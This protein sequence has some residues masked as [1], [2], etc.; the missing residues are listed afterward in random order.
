[1]ISL[2][3]MKTRIALSGTWQC[4]AVEPGR[5]RLPALRGEVQSSGEVRG[6]IDLNML[7]DIVMKVD[8]D[9]EFLAVKLDAI[10]LLLKFVYSTS[11]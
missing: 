1:M 2:A 11:S 7:G 5:A 10:H 9:L 3:G 8:D 4:E 6:N